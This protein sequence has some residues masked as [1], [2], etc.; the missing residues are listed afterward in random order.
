MDLREGDVLDGKYRIRKLI[1]S[2]GMGAVYLGEHVR[3]QRLVAIKVLQASANAVEGAV[4]RF[5]REAQAAARIGSD[6]I[7]DVFDLGLTPAGERFMVMEFLEG[8][9]MRQ[10][11]VRGECGS[12]QQ[13]IPIVT[14]LLDGLAAAHAAGIV[15]RDLKPDNIFLLR[16]KAGRPDYVKILD[17]G[18]SKF[19]QLSGGTA[20][21]TGI[22][23]GSPNYM[24]PEQV[25]SSN[26]V[27]GRSDLYAVG[28]IL[29]E[30]VTGQVPF[31]ANTFAELLFKIVYEPLPDPRSLNPNLDPEFSK[32]VIKACAQDKNARYQTAQELTTALRQYATSKGFNVSVTAPV[33]PAFLLDPAAGR[34][35]DAP[36]LAG[37]PA[38]RPS[39]PGVP[40]PPAMVPPGTPSGLRAPPLVPLPPAPPVPLGR[41]GLAPL[42]GAAPSI[43]GDVT[44]AVLQSEL[45]PEEAK[46][47]AFDPTRASGGRIPAPTEPFPQGMMPTLVDAA[48]HMTPPAGMSSS[49][50]NLAPP[51]M[52]PAF[53]T[54]G[55][56]P[57]PIGATTQGASFSSSTSRA[58]EPPRRRVWPFAVLA[59]VMGT[60]TTLAVFVVVQQ[61]DGT[62]PTSTSTAP[63]A[64]DPRSH[65]A[66]PS[67][68]ATRT[69][70]QPSLTADPSAEATS[71][72]PDVAASATP[73][74]SQTNATPEPSVSVRRPPIARPPAT[75]RPTGTAVPWY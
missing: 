29:F 54:T 39:A 15:H 60:L 11:M 62:T 20:T 45:V 23:M 14:Q 70:P 7:V 55:A 6:H 46:T 64:V 43:D 26:E 13:L 57:A 44:R 25:R 31:K 74:A 17:F 37:V 8:E 49:G 47:V 9:A 16:E 41:P 35:G 71:T 53:G 38:P 36:S 4:E 65:G 18:I 1:G 5:E 67:E 42:P 2:G 59:A 56:G 30:G 28:V 61:S 73:S 50:V 24:S 19:M 3:V 12:P 51:S 58:F 72:V 75:A 34:S 69:E 52:S 48:A 63:I 22:V 27:D 10:R 21:R 68:T 40:V 66:P 32:I 33:A